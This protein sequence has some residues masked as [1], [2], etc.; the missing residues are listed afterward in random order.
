[1]KFFKILA[2]LVLLSPLSQSAWAD[3]CVDPV[4]GLYI[5]CAPPS[6]SA[7]NS[8][9]SFTTLSASGVITS[10]L[11]TGTAPFTIASTTNVANL[12]ASTLSGKTHADPGPIGS[13]TPS[14]G[15]FTTLAASSTV[16]GTG[17]GTYLASPPAI[18]GSAAAAGNFTTLGASGLFSPTLGITATGA[19]IALNDSSNFAINIGTGT[20]TG[21]VTLGQ[22]TATPGAVAIKG[23]VSFQAGTSFSGASW[24]TTSPVW[25]GAAMTL[26]DTTASGT[27]TND[28]AYTLQA[29]N[30]TSTGGAS[31][32]ITTVGTL[33]I[34]APTCTTVIC[35]NKWAIF[36]TGGINASGSQIQGSG[37]LTITGATVNLNASANFAVNIGTG[38]TTQNVS[39]G[40]G[41]NLNTLGPT[42]ITT[43]TVFTTAA[44]TGCS[45]TNGTPGT[46][47]GGPQGGSFVGNSNGTTCSVVITINGATGKTASHGWAC[48]GS[49]ITS[50][51]ALAQS[52]TTTTTCTLK[53]TVA[54]NGD[55]IVFMAMGY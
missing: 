44:F 8:T 49:D 30:F 39:I 46:I 36:T 38:S 3:L 37:G 47:S 41:A 5:T 11:A 21:T 32:T 18:G 10:T 1:M 16:S 28:Y 29:P 43:G 42:Q 15:A 19:T 4:T 35:T 23:P 45:V 27:V 2:A 13:G 48:W 17:F 54:A 20:S 34:P 52:A 33:W 26:N 24:G 55:T 50:A 25:N 7:G 12:N 9:G 14:T 53:G 51:V 6:T 22:N 31:T 40:N